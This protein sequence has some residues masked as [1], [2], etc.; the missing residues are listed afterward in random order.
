MGMSHTHLV[1]SH[2]LLF[3]PLPF[4]C[5]NV[6]SVMSEPCVGFKQC[7]LSNFQLL[8]VKLCNFLCVL[9]VR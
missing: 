1:S 5:T 7:I 8:S 6:S 9:K 3:A 4:L 2:L